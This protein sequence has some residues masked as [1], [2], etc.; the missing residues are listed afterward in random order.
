MRLL[1]PIAAFMT[2]TAVTGSSETVDRSSVQG[3]AEVHVFE[4]SI[5]ISLFLVNSTDK[6]ITIL[7]HNTPN[8]REPNPEF[9][10]DKTTGC[11]PARFFRRTMPP[12]YVPVRTRVLP[13]SDEVLLGTY[14]IPKPRLFTEDTKIETILRLKTEDP[15]LDYVVAFKVAAIMELDPEQ[16]RFKLGQ[17]ERLKEWL[18]TAE[19]RIKMRRDFYDS[20]GPV[21]SSRPCKH[22]GCTRG[23]VKAYSLCRR[24]AYE[25]LFEKPC[26][27]ED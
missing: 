13:K 19:V 15:S 5:E 25:N 23:S 12:T 14:T 1:I 4:K 27:F 24:H 21:D 16:Q 17:E 22:E 26:P 9:V 2:L 18:D 6:E 7:W 11:I 3:R 20:F 8:S 10:I